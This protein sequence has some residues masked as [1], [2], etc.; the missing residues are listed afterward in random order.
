M[1]VF[2]HTNFGWKR[3]FGYRGAELRGGESSP[4][5]ERVFQIQVQ[6]G[7]RFLWSIHGKSNHQN[8]YC[9]DF[10]ETVWRVMPFMEI[11]W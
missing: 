7:L 1:I 10:I 4:R 3:K 5:S 2:A 9:G 8:G 11:L 6:I